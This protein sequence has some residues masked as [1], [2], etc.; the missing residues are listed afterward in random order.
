[1]VGLKIASIILPFV[2]STLCGR[3]PARQGPE[4]QVSPRWHVSRE[5]GND[6]TPSP[7]QCN[8]SNACDIPGKIVA[9]TGPNQVLDPNGLLSKL[10]EGR[11]YGI[12]CAIAFGQ[13]PSLINTSTVLCSNACKVPDGI[14]PLAGIAVSGDNGRCDISVGVQGDSEAYAVRDR[15]ISGSDQTQYCSDVLEKSKSS[16]TDLSCTVK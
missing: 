9:I 16:E 7:Q 11:L 3:I 2:G 13:R 12:T 6:T 1:M 15:S 8:T 4:V 14:D 10:R 5:N